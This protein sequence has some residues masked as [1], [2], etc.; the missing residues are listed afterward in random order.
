MILGTKQ[1]FWVAALRRNERQPLEL[2]E[3]FRTLRQINLAEWKRTPPEQLERIGQHNER[4]SAA[5]YASTS[6]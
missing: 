3:I 6:N 1:D 2:V 4:V 5:E